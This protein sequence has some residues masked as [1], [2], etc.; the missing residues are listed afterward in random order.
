MTAP[1]ALLDRLTTPGD[2][3]LAAV[4][5]LGAAAETLAL[6]GDRPVLRAALAVLTVA[7][8]ALRRRAP[9][10]SVLVVAAGLAVES[11]ATESPDETA[12]LLAVLI[13]AFSVAAYAST[14]DALTGIALLCMAIAITISVD[15]SDTLSNIAPTIL[16]FI[17]LPAAVGFAFRRRG[18]DLAAMELRTR[19]AEEEAAAAVDTERR[20]IARE[21]HDVVSHAVTLIAVQ[22]EAGQAVL[23]RDP[24]ATRRSLDAI[25]TAS[26]DA[27]AELH[28]LLELLQEPADS[29]AD[30]TD[31]GIAQL[32]TLVA[33][34]REA[35]A[36]VELAENG[37]RTALPP[38]ADH[39]AYRVVQEG[40][41]NALRHTR[42]PRVLVAID[43]QPTAVRISLHS[44]GRRHQSA[45]GGSGRGLTGLRERVAGLGG[46]LEAAPGP[47]SFSL[48]ATFP[49]EGAT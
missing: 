19:A 6:G 22:A 38:E 16:L 11:L 18:R 32:E 39:C 14:R 47:D 17:G 25:G 13:S 31:P 8:L 49:V 4:L 20:R 5:V 9:V 1:R 43:H 44:H 10:V 26:R 36:H 35:G 37:D 21:L 30:R 15:P 46:T 23:D 34:A 2:A 33:G 40:L 41:T 48:C 45:Y 28:A 7:G 29:V 24:E 42:S 3:L 12:V 27:L